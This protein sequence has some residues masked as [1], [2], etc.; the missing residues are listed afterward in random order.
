MV[1]SALDKIM[2]FVFSG[3]VK[4]VSRLPQSPF[5]YDSFFATL[6]PVLR[7]LN[8]FVP[9]YLFSDIFVAWEAAFLSMFSI[10]IAYKYAS[11]GKG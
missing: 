9:F 6:N 10:F 4:F 3:L 5:D 2:D 11:K 8:Y 7:D 1:P